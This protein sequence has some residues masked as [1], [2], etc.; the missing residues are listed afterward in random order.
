MRREAAQTSANSSRQRKADHEVASWHLRML[1]KGEDFAGSSYLPSPPHQH[2]A[3]S[4]QRGSLRFY[5]EGFLRGAVQ[6]PWLANR[7]SLAWVP[8]IYLAQ[9]TIR[10]ASNHPVPGL[11]ANAASEPMVGLS[12][13]PVLSSAFRYGQV[14]TPLRPRP[15]ASVHDSFCLPSACSTNS[16]YRSHNDTVTQKLVSQ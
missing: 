12:L 4:V 8:P 5:G 3:G 7:F 11:A 15:S 9:R 2:P 13:A 10:C 1:L 16:A 14:L 6:K